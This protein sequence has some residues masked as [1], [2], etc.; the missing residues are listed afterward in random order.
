MTNSPADWAYVP[1]YQ[2]PPLW[3]TLLQGPMGLFAWLSLALLVV[4]FIA[5]L[6]IRRIGPRRLSGAWFLGVAHIQLL[7]F[8]F[9]RGVLGARTMLYYMSGPDLLQW[10]I[11][12]KG[13]LLSLV[14]EAIALLGMV[15]LVV[16][17]AKIPFPRGLWIVSSS[18]MLV[19]VLMWFSLISA[20]SGMASAMP[21]PW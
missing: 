16:R 11:D 17:R 19:D 13:I 6:A 18:L 2:G 7:V 9:V 15:L 1:E 21:Q 20:I 3:F 4:C 10:S 14:I 5:A 8:L 12:I